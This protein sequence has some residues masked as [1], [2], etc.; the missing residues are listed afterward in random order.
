[1]EAIQRSIELLDLGLAI[2]VILLEA[3]GNFNVDR[4]IF[5]KRGMEKG[6]SDISL[7]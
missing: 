4:F 5:P 3:L 7:L 2:F 1:M 6:T